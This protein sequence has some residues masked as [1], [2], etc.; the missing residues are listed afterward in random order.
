MAHFLEDYKRHKKYTGFGDCG[1]T[2][3]RLENKFMRSALQLKNKQQG[4]LVKKVIRFAASAADALVVTVPADAPPPAADAPAAAVPADAGD[5]VAVAAAVAAAAVA[6]A[7]DNGDGGGDGDGAAAAAA[8]VAFCCCCCCCCCCSNSSSNSS[9]SRNSCSN[10]SSRVPT[11]SS[12]TRTSIEYEQHQRLSGTETRRVFPCLFRLLCF[13]WMGLR[14]L[15][16]YCKE[17]ISFYLLM[18]KK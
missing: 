4:V 16:M 6:A 7:E 18:A 5:G 10:G 13:R 17:E 9:S 2:W 11:T 3:Q 8:P 14:L 15:A 12:I 1:F